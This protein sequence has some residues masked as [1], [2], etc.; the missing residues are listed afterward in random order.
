M[1]RYAQIFRNGRVSVRRCSDDLE[2]AAFKAPAAR[3]VW[4][5]GFSPD[6]RYLAASQTPVGGLTV[7]DLKERRAA[8]SVRGDVGHGVRFSP[9]SRRIVVRGDGEVL[10][11]NLPGGQLVRRWPGRMLSLA[12]RPDGAQIAW[13]DSGS[14]PPV[15]RILDWDTGAPVRAFMLPARSERTRLEARRRYARDLQRR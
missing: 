10:D 11:Y 13:I 9:D 1:T 2:I 4:F 3:D 14:K 6:G 12:F 15:C 8:L 5:F 7:W